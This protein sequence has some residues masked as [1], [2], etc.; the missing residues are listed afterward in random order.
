MQL[1]I[2]NEE[3]R[4]QDVR[5][6]LPRRRTISRTRQHGSSGIPTGTG[7]SS[8]LRAPRCVMRR[9]V[10]DDLKSEGFSIRIIDAYSVDRE[11]LPRAA[12]DTQGKLV[13]IADYW[14]EGT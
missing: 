3:G 5:V 12:R 14:C 8:S 13:G 4:N 9:K 7:P 11:A 10:R 2:Q 6:R 1:L